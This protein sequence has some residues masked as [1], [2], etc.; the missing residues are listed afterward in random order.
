M[1]VIEGLSGQ[2]PGKEEFEAAR[3]FFN[4]LPKLEPVNT[5]KF[6]VSGREIKALV[7]EVDGQVWLVGYDFFASVENGKIRSFFE[8]S[9]D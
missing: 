8:F 4:Q 9:L 6:E 1:S 3:S 2:E 7:Y 5:A